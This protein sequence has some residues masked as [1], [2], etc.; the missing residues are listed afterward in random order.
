[1]A[2]VPLSA[3]LTLN[4]WPYWFRLLKHPAPFSHNT[5]WGGRS[6]QWARLA[7][8]EG[9][10]S[11]LGPR[12]RPTRLSISTPH[13]LPWKPHLSS[14]YLPGLPMAPQGKPPLSSIPRGLVSEL[15][16][17]LLSSGGLC[18]GQSALSAHS[19]VLFAHPGPSL[20]PV[21]EACPFQGCCSGAAPF[22]FLCCV[23]S[24]S[25]GLKASA[26]TCGFVG[27]GVTFVFQLCAGR[28]SV[29]CSRG[30]HSSGCRQ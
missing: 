23:I 18:P 5:G 10:P 16:I 9:S 26:D 6:L 15:F 28:D 27:F 19:H 20:S 21:D 12:S 14:Q 11:R 17:H 13:A 4:V 3:V 2:L 7:S 1:M 25:A 24:C 30:F 29:P 8:S 22:T